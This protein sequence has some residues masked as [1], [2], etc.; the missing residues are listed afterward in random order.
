MFK[1]PSFSFVFSSNPYLEWMILTE[2]KGIEGEEFQNMHGFKISEDCTR[3]DSHSWRG[4][5]S[6]TIPFDL[7]PFH[8]VACGRNLSFRN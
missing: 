8:V 3:T 6:K 2:K 4:T 5:P 1:S 7:H